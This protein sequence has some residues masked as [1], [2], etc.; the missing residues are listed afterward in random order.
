VALISDIHFG[1]SVFITETNESPWPL[2]ESREGFTN[3][4]EVSNSNRTLFLVNSS[5]SGPHSNGIEVSSMTEGSTD[6]LK[7]IKFGPVVLTRRSSLTSKGR[8]I[9]L[10]GDT[11]T[12][13]LLN[14]VESLSL[15]L[16]I[17]EETTRKCK[18]GEMQISV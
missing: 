17:R 10:G 2:G 13:I 4:L 5:L 15:L 8:R 9:D 18:E 12:T 16:F 3:M 7:L 6:D 11:E 14:L 1:F